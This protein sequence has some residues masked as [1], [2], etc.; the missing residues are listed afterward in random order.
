MINTKASAILCLSGLV[1][2]VLHVVPLEVVAFAVVWFRLAMVG[3]AF[4]EV[5]GSHCVAVALGLVPMLAQ[6]V[7]QTVDL[8]VRRPCTA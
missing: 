7:T 5:R 3:Q 4:Q 8:A 6:G 2:A 1:P